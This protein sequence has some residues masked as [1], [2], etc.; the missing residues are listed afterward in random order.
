M[1]LFI[2]LYSSKFT[3]HANASLSV[4][5]LYVRMYILTVLCLHTVGMRVSVCVAT[6][7]RPEN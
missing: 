1:V 4:H 6:V 5:V 7:C 2:Y 3:L